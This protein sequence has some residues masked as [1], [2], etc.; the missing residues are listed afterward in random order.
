MKKILT[1]CFAVLL[2]IVDV[3]A[4]NITGSGV[5]YGG[6]SVDGKGLE[7]VDSARYV[8]QYRYVESVLKGNGDPEDLCDSLYLCVGNK[9]SVFYDPELA[10]KVQGY[11]SSYKL[12]ARKA[13]RL[14]NTSMDRIP[15]EDVQSMREAT[16]DFVEMK[17]GDPVQVYKDYQSGTTHTLLVEN[18]GNAGPLLQCDESNPEF[19]A[20]QM[21][22]GTK[23]VLGYSCNKASVEY[24]G[25]RYTAWFA[26]DLPIQDGPWKFRGLPGLILMVTDD[27]GLFTYEAV[28]IQT[29][30][31][32]IGR[33]DKAYTK[34]SRKDFNKVLLKY[35][36]TVPMSFVTN[37]TM[38]HVKSESSVKYVLKEQ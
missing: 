23:E 3:G 38:Y 35:M 7:I 32:A 24:A 21:Q 4:Q 6:T 26:L 36:T 16:E 15:L 25:R 8:V 17:F 28:G 14:G 12:L 9:V 13:T 18:S 20:W 30:Q 37:G 33:D 29:A 5:Y 10:A 1:F 2:C 19:L 22:E 11:R 27:D 31:G 34:C